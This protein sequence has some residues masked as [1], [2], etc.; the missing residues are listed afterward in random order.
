[1]ARKPDKA[2]DW[3][4]QKLCCDGCV[5]RELIREDRCRKEHVCVQDRSPSRIEEF[6]KC[7]PELA[8]DF[9][10][11]PYFEVRAA[12]ARHADIFRLTALLS[13]EDESV[14][15]NAALR[16][17]HRFLLRLRDD[18]HR[19]VRIRVASH[20]EGEE[21][22]PMMS[23]PDYF[24]RQVVARRIG[25]PQLKNM[26]DDPD[27]EVRRVVAQ[28]IAPEWL[29]EL[30]N[31]P[32]TSVCLEV[33]QRLAPAQL[34]PLRHHPALRVRYEVAGRIPVNALDAMRADADPL[35]RERV[36]ERL[37]AAHDAQDGEHTVIEMHPARWGGKTHG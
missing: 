35:V 31:D 33:A 20:L 27:P 21:L 29:V 23:D 4:G 8:N 25:T 36:K 9:L 10:T 3:M 7:N 1:M 13:D 32:D 22:A 12:A 30:I 5:H 26:I 15:W 18:P 6:F 11:H 17:P 16:L 37:A 19:E 14:R 2:V 34:L 24:V 28:R